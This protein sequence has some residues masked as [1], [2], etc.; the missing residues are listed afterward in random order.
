[1]GL[2]TG[3]GFSEFLFFRYVNTLATA[4][5]YGRD[6]CREMSLSS[7]QPSESQPWFQNRILSS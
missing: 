3:T 7:V 5:L 4:G 1:M 2:D 6:W